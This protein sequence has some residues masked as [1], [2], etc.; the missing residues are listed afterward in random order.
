[1]DVSSLYPSS[2][3]GVAFTNPNPDD[4]GK[5]DRMPLWA[6]ATGAEKTSAG[7]WGKAQL[8]IRAPISAY[9][10]FGPAIA[11]WVFG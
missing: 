8:D 7:C 2:S 3:A 11:A 10:A 9:A 6:T 4:D 5:P 1:M